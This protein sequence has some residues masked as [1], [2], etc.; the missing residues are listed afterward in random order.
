MEVNY[1]CIS[2][3]KL[4]K[5]WNAESLEYAIAHGDHYYG[6]SRTDIEAVLA[7]GR[8]ILRLIDGMR[9]EQILKRK[10][11]F[12]MVT[13]F[14]PPKKWINSSNESLAGDLKRRNQLLS[15]CKRQKMR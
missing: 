12:P 8:D 10:N 11:D 2:K 6:S 5:K 7:S 14:I 3:E 1:H 4:L 15:V 9:V 13:I